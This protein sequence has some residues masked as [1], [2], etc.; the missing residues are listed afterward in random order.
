MNGFFA[1][2]AA[3]D[4]IGV[5]FMG[6]YDRDYTQHDYDGGYRPQ[7]RM[8]F[9]RITGVVK[10]LL[11]INVV[12]FVLTVLF[13]PLADFAFTWLSVYPLTPLM[14]LQVW[15]PIT[16]QFLHDTNGFAHIFFNMIVLYFFGIMLERTWGPRKFL[17][18]YLM[19][20][21]VG[22]IV[23]P[24]LAYIGW[25]PKLPLVGASGGI[26]GMIAACAIMFPNMR[27]LVFFVFPVRLVIVALVLAGYAILTLLRP[28][29][30]G[31]AGGEA[32]HLGGMVAGAVYVL[33][34]SWRSH[35]KSKFRHRFGEKRRVSQFN[36]Q[37]D[38]DNILDKVHREGIGS[39]TRREKRVLKQATELERKRNSL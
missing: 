6:L 15:R 14:S 25:L 27:V 33:S 32:A 39:L 31:N 19:C 11:I 28:G 3:G 7:M 29:Q 37:V 16:Y 18:F 2:A 21:A 12:V 36:L 22:G 23:Y 17:R 24:F 35:F 1:P 13:R 8:V 34:E 20:G 38:L 9:P 10:I 26:L 4:D 5:S 30:F